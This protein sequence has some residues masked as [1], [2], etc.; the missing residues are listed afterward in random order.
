MFVI[1]KK[2]YK[3]NIINYDLKLINIVNGKE[4]KSISI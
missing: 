3:K 4:E 2:I 1:I